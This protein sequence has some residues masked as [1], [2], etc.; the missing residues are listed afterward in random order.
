[1]LLGA[2]LALGLP[3]AELKKA[4][5]SLPLEE[6]NLTICPVQKC[7]ISAIYFN[8]ELHGHIDHH[9][10]H[11]RHLSDINKII[12][13]SSLPQIV[14]DTSKKIFLNLAAAEGKIHGT[15]IENIHFHEVGA[16]DAIIDIV[17]C[18]YALYYFDIKKIFVSKL[19]TGFG[20]TNCSHGTIPIPAP[21]TAELLTNIPYFKGSI[22]KE[23]VTPTGAAFV[24]SVGTPSEDFPSNFIVKQVGYGAGTWDLP[25]PNVLRAHLGEISYSSNET[26]ELLVVEANIDDLNP[27][28]YAYVM[29]ALL[30]AGALDVWLTPIIMKKSRPASM[31]S[32]LTSKANLESMLSIIFK[33]T[34]TIG[35]RYYPS[36]R[37]TASREILAVETPWGEINVKFSSYNGEICNISPE[38]EDCQKIAY[39]K[40]VPLKKVQQTALS[41][42][43]A[44]LSGIKKI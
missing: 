39:D 38:Y 13:Q 40:K 10:H 20:F 6:Y 4:L 34:T 30:G 26:E 22:E 27:Q 29:E 37:R 33:E 8:T 44:K 43:L 15:S 42:S 35:L 25:I 3:E 21:A 14:K 17:G 5:S 11:H 2:F 24:K 31:L 23:L 32:F 18:A 36:I 12:D 19:Q 9:E 28:V 7:G 1:M 16:V 41:L